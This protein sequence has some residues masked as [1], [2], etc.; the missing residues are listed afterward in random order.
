MNEQELL[1]RLGQ[2]IKKI[3]EQK[4][5]KQ[6]DLANALEYDRSNMSR[7]ESGRVNPRFTT[8]IKVAQELNVSLPELLDIDY[9]EGNKH[10]K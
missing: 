10:S 5:I 7:L 1:W 9:S 6:V 2:K 3:R 4:N 8:L